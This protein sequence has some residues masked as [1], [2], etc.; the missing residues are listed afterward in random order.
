MK[1]TRQ[2][3]L[4]LNIK[5]TNGKWK[6]PH[7]I[8]LQDEDMKARELPHQKMGLQRLAENNDSVEEQFRQKNG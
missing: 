8:I 1:R 7:P 5:Q 2:G 3:V 6:E 4:D